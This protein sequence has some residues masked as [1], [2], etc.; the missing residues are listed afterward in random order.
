MISGGSTVAS[1]VALSL[2]L[3]PHD[4]AFISRGLCAAVLVAWPA[5]ASW[6][7]LEDGDLGLQRRLLRHWA[8]AGALLLAQPVA[9]KAIGREVPFYHHAKLEVALYLTVRLAGWPGL[10]A[11][12]APGICCGAGGRR[13]AVRI[14]GV[15]A[16]RRCNRSGA[17]SLQWM[18]GCLPGRRKQVCRVPT[19]ALEHTAGLC[20]GRAGKVKRRGSS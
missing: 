9:D 15:V 2:L 4:D 14:F 20:P 13:V 5:Y 1:S 10:D 17:Q 8:A 7:S 16:V 11:L 19:A 18:R 6:R 3:S 12:A